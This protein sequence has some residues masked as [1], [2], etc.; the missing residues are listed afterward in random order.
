[1]TQCWNFIPSERPSFTHIVNAVEKFLTEFNGYFEM[2]DETGIN[3]T[4]KQLPASKNQGKS[5]GEG[6]DESKKQVIVF[7]I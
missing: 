5:S 6:F 3:S 2:A 7:N 1:M 4:D